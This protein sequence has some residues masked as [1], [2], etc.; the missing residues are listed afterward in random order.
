LNDFVF[1]SSSQ[2]PLT[3][4]T[5]TGDITLNNVDVNNQGNTRNT[6]S[7]NSS[8][9]DITV[10]NGTYDGN[11][12]NSSGFSA[13]TGGSITITDSSFTD[14][15][16]P[17]AVTAN[18]ATLSAPIVTLNNVTAT[19]NDG[20]G[21]FFAGSSLFVNGGVFSNNGRY[22]LELAAPA[23]TTLA[24]ASAPACTG[25][26]IG[27]T[28]AVDTTP[29]TLILPSD[30]TV[31]ASG[32]AVVIYSASATDNMDP[33]VLVICLPS[34]GSLFPLG[35]TTVNCSAADSASNFAFGSF[36]VTVQDSTVVVLPTPPAGTPGNSGSTP[37]SSPSQS[38]S[39]ELII[40]VTGGEVI[41]LD[42]NSIFWAFGIKLSFTGL[43]DYQTTLDDIGIDELPG[44]LPDGTSFVTGLDLRLL[45]QNQTIDELP[46]GA[47]VQLDFP[48]LG[49][50]TGQFTVLHWNG[51]EW[52]ELSQQAGG[53][54]NFY[55][56]S[57][58]DKAGI[59]VLVKK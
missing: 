39:L 50:A 48:L 55:Q 57:V 33:T 26:T 9:G 36:Q 5:T 51:S 43:C 8:S 13:T 12:S 25:N 23:A 46:E 17:G 56:V 44:A 58:T 10:T 47:A 22:G 59:F 53:D 18:G 35:T 42:C 31:S 34:S 54:P 41:G 16:R 15:R 27:C 37:G 24:I 21:V 4:Y 40:P 19:G 30:I 32:P 7:L 14:N 45:R 28:N 1:N 3:V 38:P 2:V 6:A 52:V 29:P 11:G 49:D 20:S